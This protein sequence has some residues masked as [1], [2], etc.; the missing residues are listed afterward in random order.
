[1]SHEAGFRRGSRDFSHKSGPARQAKQRGRRNYEDRMAKRF[2]EHEKDIR[3]KA[4]EAEE[5]E[6]TAEAEEDA[7][8]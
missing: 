5:A 1:M 4:E 6:E 3:T 8:A 2:R 7:E